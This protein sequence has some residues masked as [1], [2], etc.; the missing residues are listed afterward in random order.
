MSQVTSPGCR[1]AASMGR[2]IVCPP[3]SSVLKPLFLSLELTLWLTGSLFF[4]WTFAPFMTPRT[5]GS[6]MQFFWSKTTSTC[7]AADL[8]SSLIAVGLGM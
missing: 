1:S 6:K 5:C 4:T 7:E 8:A 3:D 2:A